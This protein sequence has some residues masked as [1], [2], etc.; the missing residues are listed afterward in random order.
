MKSCI[1][2]ASLGRLVIACQSSATDKFCDVAHEAK[3][4]G[5]K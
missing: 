2:V 4:S 3:E 1:F 5:E